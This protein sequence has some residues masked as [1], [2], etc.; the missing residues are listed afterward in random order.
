M[1]NYFIPLQP[2]ERGSIFKICILLLSDFVIFSFEYT[3]ELIWERKREDSFQN[4]RSN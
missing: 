3:G 2:L 1:Q 4:P